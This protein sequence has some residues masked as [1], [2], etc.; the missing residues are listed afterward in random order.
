MLI[1]ISVFGRYMLNYPDA[2][3][4]V[5]R[6]CCLWTEKILPLTRVCKSFVFV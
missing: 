6:T 2:T 4:K 5:I 3:N 1:I